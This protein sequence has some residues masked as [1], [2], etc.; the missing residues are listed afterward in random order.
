MIKS[1]ILIKGTTRERLKHR[2]SKGETYDNL[3]N[4]LLN[5]DGKSA[6]HRVGNMKSKDLVE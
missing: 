2:G 6:N 3:I 5:E 4:R 1:T